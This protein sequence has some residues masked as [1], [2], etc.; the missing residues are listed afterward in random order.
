MET[1]ANPANLADDLA[2]AL[3]WWRV[4]GVDMDF[5]EDATD[6]LA[7]G[8]AAAA[9]PPQAAVPQTAPKPTAR[10]RKAEAAKKPAEPV[11]GDKSSWPQELGQ[12]GQWW[13]DEPTLDEGGARPRIAPRGQPGAKLMIVVPHPEAEDTDKLLSAQQGVLLS[14]ML[15]AMQIAEDDAYVASALPRFTP[16]PDWPAIAAGG[17]G[18]VLS[19]HL[20]LAAPQRVLIMGRGIL[21]LI[22]HDMAQGSVALREFNHV[23]ASVGCAAGASLETMLAQ[24]GERSR[25]WRRWLEWTA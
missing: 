13:L 14:N 1:S 23:S 25:F 19:H 12:F 15:R 6:W 4:A 24:P 3:D 18:E 2:S 22:P 7:D 10:T 16:L 20:K 8:V 17:M 11:G 5:A 21:S 9:P